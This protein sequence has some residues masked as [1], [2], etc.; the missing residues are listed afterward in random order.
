MYKESR[1]GVGADSREH[2]G[3]HLYGVQGEGG[4]GLGKGLWGEV[5]VWWGEVGYF[6]LTSVDATALFSLFLYIYIFF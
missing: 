4:Q 1:V 2:L 5:C 6:S 3:N